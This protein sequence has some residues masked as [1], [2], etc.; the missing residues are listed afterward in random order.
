MIPQH[1]SERLLAQAAQATGPVQLRRG[2]RLVDAGSIGDEAVLAV[3]GPDTDYQLQAAW[4]VAA[5]G[6]RST[7]RR[8]LGPAEAFTI[9]GLTE[10]AASAGIKR[11]Q[12]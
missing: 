8:A 1:H 4:A 3:A 10:G 2:H 11:A 7:V 12:G 9:E 5:D 6:A